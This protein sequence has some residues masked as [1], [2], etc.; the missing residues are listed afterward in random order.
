MCCGEAKMFM[1]CVL[2]FCVPALGDYVRDGGDVCVPML[3]C[4][5]C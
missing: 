3:V 5:Q 1:G 2:L 4:S